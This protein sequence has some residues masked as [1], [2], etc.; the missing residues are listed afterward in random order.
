MMI[1]RENPNRFRENLFQCQF[2][3]HKS[4]LIRPGLN[5]WLRAFMPTFNW[6]NDI[7]PLPTFL[8]RLFLA[9]FPYFEKIERNL[10]DHLAVCV[11]VCPPYLFVFY[12]VRVVSTESSRLILRRT[13]CN[14]VLLSMSKSFKN[15]LSFRFPQ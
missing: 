2:V 1:K 14:I 4:T 8:L 13:S 10:W 11:S 5:Q 12:A 3:H 7:T 6:L 15:F 9:C